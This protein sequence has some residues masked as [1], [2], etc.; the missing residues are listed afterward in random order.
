[1]FLQ[2]WSQP[3]TLAALLV[4]SQLYAAS[5]PAVEAQNGMVVTSQHLASQVGVD[6]LKMG[7]TRWM[8]R[9]RSAMPKR[10]LTPAAAISAVAVS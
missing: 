2:K 6:I 10:W 9:S 8:R 4:S 3:L 5:N 7:A 1:M